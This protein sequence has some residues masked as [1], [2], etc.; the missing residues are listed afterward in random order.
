M[1]NNALPVTR[2]TVVQPLVDA[3]AIQNPQAAILIGGTD[4][5]IT[6]AVAEG[7]T[8]TGA[9]LTYHPP[10][11]VYV[12]RRVDLELPVTMT[13]TAT[14]PLGINVIET[15]YDALRAYPLA[16]IMS[17]AKFSI[18]G[19]A[20]IASP[21]ADY[22]K[23]L[24]HF[25]GF[26]TMIDRGYTTTATMLDNCQEYNEVI[27]TTRNPL[28][29]AYDN[30][31]QVPRGSAVELTIV[32]AT[33]DGVN[34]QTATVS[35]TLREPLFLS[36][37]LG[38]L[39]QLPGYYDVANLSLQIQ[40]VNNL[41]AKL[42]SHNNANHNI[43]A[44]TVAFGNLTAYFTHSTPKITSPTAIT[45]TYP[46]MELKHVTTET[47]QVASLATTTINSSTFTQ[48]HVP[49]YVW[50]WV[51][52]R[53]IDKTIN[54]TDAYFRIN[55]VTITYDGKQPLLSNA[56]VEILYELTAKNGYDYDFQE[57]F[58]T[59]QYTSIGGVE[60]YAP[61]GG[62][63]LC[64]EFGTDI[65]LPADV[66][67]GQLRN[68]Q[69]SC[70]VN[71]T[72]INRTRAITP[73]L[74]VLFGTY[75]SVSILNRKAETQTG[76]V[77]TEDT[78]IA[79]DMNSERELYP[80]YTTEIYGGLGFIP[81]QIFRRR[82]KP[83]VDTKKSF[84]TDPDVLETAAKVLGSVVGLGKMTKDEKKKLMAGVRAGVISPREVNALAKKR[85]AAKPKP[86][87]KGGAM[88]TY[89]N[90]ESPSASSTGGYRKKKSFGGRKMTT[91][92]ML[93]QLQ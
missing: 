14:P 12:S 79:Q 44:T 55:S 17:G 80:N 50:I 6:A 35:F 18:N 87:T 84:F 1:S 69:F 10:S 13:F 75:G 53:E 78:L 41:A 11:N 16:S 9:T 70:Q 64:F 24:M 23:E 30:A 19:T 68:N 67:P 90:I 29:N 39:S 74:H 43:D 48:G 72:N 83:G 77:R 56:P 36:P 8:T 5:T 52:E 91:E 2:K 47:T 81:R 4:Y 45:A 63:I 38:T 33:G 22:V 76:I 58:G 31:Y 49:S 85:L 25:H 7:T 65:G 92:Q 46:Y 27:N 82:V 34:P 71:V 88:I 37:C 60:T 3:Y 93:K 42:W 73:T 89:K 40:F 59:N 32:N 86:K 28:A 61:M 26:K 21:V 66:A 54:R 57:W 62:S 15:G 20:S 51:N